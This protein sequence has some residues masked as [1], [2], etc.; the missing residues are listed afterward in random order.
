MRA[1][2]FQSH[3]A[4]TLKE[5]KARMA[6]K[7]V[8]TKTSAKKSTKKSAGKGASKKA[9]SKGAGA[10]KSSAQ[11]ATPSQGKC[12]SWAAWHDR[13]PFGPATLHVVGKCRF[14]TPGY[15]VTLK[16]AVPQGINPA[17]LLLQK[18]VRPPTGKVIPAITVVEA[19]YSEQT[20][21]LY[22]AVTILPEV[23]TIKVQQVS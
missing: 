12:F 2:L 1:F 10:K 4:P 15:K 3:I 17:I 21:A 5:G 13:M 6:T 20:N 22:T 7:K 23:K 9:G 19:R 18:V 16:K 14:P 8:A 11:K